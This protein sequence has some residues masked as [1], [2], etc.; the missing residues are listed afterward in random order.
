MA[1]RAAK[2]GDDMRILVT[3]G[4]G[5][6]GSATI[7]YAVNVAGATVLNIDKLTYAATPEAL[8]DAEASGRYSFMQADICDRA[9]LAKAFAEFAPDA[10]LHLAAESH[11]D[12]S[13]EGPL[14]FITTN[15]VGTTV[16]LEAARHYW[17]TLDPIAKR[18][19]RFHHIST[20]EVYGSLEL[21]EPGFTERTPYR[22]RSPYSASKAGSDHLVRAWGETY[23]L[24]VMVT[25]CSNNYG[26]WQ[27]PEKLIPVMILNCRRGEPLPVYGEGRNIRDWL[28]VDDH[29]RALWQ[30]LTRGRPGETYNIGGLSE[31]RNI[32]VVHTVCRLMDQRFPHRAPHDRLV[33]FVP[34]RLGHDLRYAVE[35]DKIRDE[36]GWTPTVNFEAGLEATLDW[37]LAHEDWWRRVLAQGSQSQRPQDVAT[38]PQRAAG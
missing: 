24:P 12:R 13:I 19:F 22:P 28:H 26:P 8:E 16:L 6:I 18:C 3:G 30:V 33:R 5:F 10:V 2:L 14:A 20:D 17:S 15:V 23:G 7:R 21:A 29:A 32:D 11:V 35:A 36:L 4:C 9:A 1:A 37:Y 38:E 25:N 31:R 27:F 34:D